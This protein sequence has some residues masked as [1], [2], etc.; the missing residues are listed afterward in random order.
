[1][2]K[3]L[4]TVGTDGKYLKIIKVIYQHVIIANIILNGDILSI[5]SKIRNEIRKVAHSTYFL[6][7]QS[8]SCSNYTRDI[9]GVI[10]RGKATLSLFLF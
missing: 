3:A 5:S 6:Q 8:L 10:G 4:E 9:K 2:I 7:C 1:M